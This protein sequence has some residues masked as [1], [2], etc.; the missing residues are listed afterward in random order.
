MDVRDELWPVM[1][2][3]RAADYAYEPADLDMHWL[4]IAPSELREEHIVEAAGFVRANFGVPAEALYRW[5]AGR[6][7]HPGEP[8]AWETLP[9]GRRLALVVFCE[10]LWL[11][12]R[13][14]AA[15]DARLAAAAP[16]PQPPNMV[17]E[18]ETIMARAGSILDRVDDAP[19][20]INLGGPDAPQAVAEPGDVGADDPGPGHQDP[21]AP[22]APAVQADGGS[23]AT[24]P[25]GVAHGGDQPPA[26]APPVGSAPGG[27]AEPVAGAAAEPA[28]APVTEPIWQNPTQGPAPARSKKS[29]ASS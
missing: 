27:L 13:E 2:A 5:S 23:A 1:L 15:E 17:R 3:S 4:S 21:G 11:A 19:R 8:S 18:D 12:D 6:G 24:D 16:A 26:D 9:F 29:R 7:M 10:L 20:M 14:R 25:A 22:L 28:E